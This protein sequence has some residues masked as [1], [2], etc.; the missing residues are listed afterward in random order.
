MQQPSKKPGTDVIQEVLE[1]CLLAFP[2]SS[3]L[4]SLYKQ[5]GQRGFLT[6]KQLEGLYAK[7]ATVPDMQPG[8]LATLEAIIKK[9]PNRYKSALPEAQPVFEKDPVISGLLDAILEKYP[10]HKRVLFLKSKFDNNEVLS[11]VEIDELKRFHRMVK[12]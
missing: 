10:Q 11:V 12:K 2:V 4:I 5:Y 7:A 3:L 8:R 9:M 6:K 1:D